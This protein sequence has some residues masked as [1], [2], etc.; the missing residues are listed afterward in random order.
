MNYRKVPRNTRFPFER[1]PGM[2]GTVMDP[3]WK[4]KLFP[5]E[6]ITINEPQFSADYVKMDKRIIFQNR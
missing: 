1:L 4:C 2:A 3:I 6:I 5:L